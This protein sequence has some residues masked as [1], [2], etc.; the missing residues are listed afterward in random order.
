[1]EHFILIKQAECKMDRGEIMRKL[2]SEHDK[3][4]AEHDTKNDNIY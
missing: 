4:I 2:P 1:M 3:S